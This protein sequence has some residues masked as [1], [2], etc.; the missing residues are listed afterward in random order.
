MKS[1]PCFLYNDFESCE[2]II[3]VYDFTNKIN[4]VIKN[5]YDHLFN[6]IDLL[7]KNYSRIFNK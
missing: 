1:F 3:L 2:F 4:S 7:K 5:I 6:I